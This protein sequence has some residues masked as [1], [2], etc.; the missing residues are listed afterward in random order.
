MHCVFMSETM[1]QRDTLRVQVRDEYTCKHNRLECG[2]QGLP[3]TK[4]TRRTGRQALY[5]DL[6]DQFV[7]R[8]KRRQKKMES[9]RFAD[10]QMRRKSRLQRGK[11][12]QGLLQQYSALVVESWSFR[13]TSQHV[14]WAQE[15]SRCKVIITIFDHTTQVLLSH[16]F[17][18]CT[19][20]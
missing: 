7:R 17:S 3:G 1:T 12:N 6:I 11:I 14:S 9:A 20:P 16:Y 8:I 5:S 4:E 13:K 2:F 10:M 19:F 18:C 15:L